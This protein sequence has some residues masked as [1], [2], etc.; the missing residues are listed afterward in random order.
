[1]RELP[2]SVCGKTRVVK[3]HEFGFGL[4]PE[5]KKA[6][7][8]FLKLK[9]LQLHRASCQAEPPEGHS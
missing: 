7:V 9:T 3:G 8:A 6:L 1:M 4:S 5:E 2:S